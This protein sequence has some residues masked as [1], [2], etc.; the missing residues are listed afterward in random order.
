MT[1]IRITLLLL[2]AVAGAFFSG[3][4]LLQHYNESHAVAMV[5]SM[6]G[7][8]SASGC[9]LINRSKYATFLSIPLAAFGLFFYL[10][11]TLLATLLFFGDTK[12]REV[13]GRFAFFGVCAA[14]LI[15]IYLLSVQI[16]NLKTFCTLCLVTYAI[17]I[18]LLIILLP[19]RRKIGGG[20]LKEVLHRSEGKLL[21]FSWCA[22]S[23]ILAVTVG[24]VN[25]AMLYQDPSTFDARLDDIA[26]KEFLKS[27]ELVIDLVGAPSEGV[28]EAPIKI[29]LYG[30][31][32]CP[33]CRQLALTIQ[34]HIKK[35]Q[36]NVIVYYKYYPLDQQCNP[37]D[38]KNTHPGSCWASV[39][40]LC[41]QA[42][43][44]FWE[45]HDRIYAVPPRKP[46]PQDILQIGA[47]A[48]LDT[49]AMKSCMNA[50]QMKVMIHKFV[51]EAKSD[52]VTGAP[53]V[54]INGKK[55]PRLGY[56]NSVLTK[57]A[58]RLGLES[59]NATGE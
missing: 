35:W 24:A 58:Q 38:T 9:S 17:T 25:L 5:S 56:F 33:W 39:G 30:D 45:Y 21:L 15:D 40:G 57:E 54:F 1:R 18:L 20:R 27:P 36:P 7:G 13:A 51:E 19:Y 50:L 4:L 34:Q 16:F 47:D 28:A 59:L 6:C 3:L 42:Q 12:T 23:A 10:S 2:C 43:G 41:A 26:Y 53:T 37:Y 11:L 52:G 29:V 55:L 31:F 32:L 49:T 22:G 48:G 44:H 8:E 46:S 14:L